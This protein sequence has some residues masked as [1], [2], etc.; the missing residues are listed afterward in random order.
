[1][2]EM[3]SAAK[4]NKITTVMQNMLNESKK[5]LILLKGCANVKV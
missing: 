4:I 1:L 5:L 3:T 2:Y